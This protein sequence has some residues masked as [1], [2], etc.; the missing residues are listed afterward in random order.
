MGDGGFEPEL[1]KVEDWL[2]AILRFAVTREQTDRAAILAVA[3]DMDRL[4]APVVRCGF[5][6]F[7]KTSIEICDLIVS[8]HSSQDKAVLLRHLGKIEND[9]LR[10]ALEVALELPRF[11]RTSVRTRDQHN[12]DLWRG[13]PCRH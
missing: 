3:A 7:V 10:R 5:T 4:G 11:D 13:L 9:R 12:G 1:R 2:L 6:F 8:G